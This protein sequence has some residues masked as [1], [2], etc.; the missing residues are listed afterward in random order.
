MPSHHHHTHSLKYF[1]SFHADAPIVFRDPNPFMDP[2]HV[3]FTSPLQMQVVASSRFNASSGS[4]GLC[5]RG[6]VTR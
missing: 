1:H 4:D 3:A 2:E 5:T 6:V